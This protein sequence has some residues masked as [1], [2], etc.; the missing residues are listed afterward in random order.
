[1][2]SSYKHKKFYLIFFI[3]M[4]ILSLSGCSGCSTV[5]TTRQRTIVPD[6]IPSSSATVLP[7]ELSKYD[8]NGYGKWHYG[9][10]LDSVKRLDIMPAAYSVVGVG[11][12]AKLL[13]FFTITDIHIADKESPA[14]AI[15]MY[16]QGASSSGYSGTMLYTTQVLDA[17]VRTI[18]SLHQNAPFDFGISL[19]DTC[20][21]TQYNEL[22]WYIDVLDGKIITPSSGAHAGNDTIDYQQPYRAAGLDKTIPWYQAVGNHDHFWMG[23]LSPDDYIRQHLIGQEIINLGN[24]FIVQDG[25]ASRGYY[26]GAIDGSTPYGDVI[27]SGAVSSFT[28]PPTVPAADPDRRSLTKKE[29]MNEFLTTSSNPVGHGFTQANVDNDFGCYS[30]EP[31]SDIP[32]K[33][34]V[35]DDTQSNTDSNDPIVNGYGAGSFGY[36]HGTLD[37]D[38]YNWLISEL[39]KG[40]AE[41]KLMIIAAHIPIGVQPAPSMMCWEPTLEET[42]LAKLHTYPNFMLWIAGHRHFNTVTAFKSPDDAHPEFGFWQVETSSLKDFPQQFRTF[43]ISRNSD[44]T[45]SIFTTDVDTDVEDGSLAAKSR[46]YAVGAQQIYNNKIALLPTASYNAELVKQLSVEMQTKIKGY[47]IPIG[48]WPNR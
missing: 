47:G 30:F 19:G 24:P 40:Q 38:R 31:R 12:A 11:E 28:T 36:G 23:F 7:Y 4:L 6:A 10:G 26:M 27:G 41:G 32:I 16:N 33:V 29:W 9:A 8:Q 43:K 44:N 17:A 42:L 15:A 45:I 25:N 34:I 18:N 21:S 39:D 5:S 3:G 2:K 14:Q 1:M 46:T 48:S 20:N 22:R 13:N 35:I 37:N